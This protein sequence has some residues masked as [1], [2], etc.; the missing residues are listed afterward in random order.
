V[1]RFLQALVVVGMSLSIVLAGTAW[2]QSG[3]FAAGASAARSGTSITVSSITPCFSPVSGTPLVRVF[4]GRGSSTLARST[5]LV[6]SSG[7]WAGRLTIPSAA[8]PGSAQLSAFCFSGP[9]AEGAL[10][11]YTPHDFTIL[12]GGQVEELAATGRKSWRVLIGGV[13]LVFLGALIALMSSH[14]WIVTGPGERAD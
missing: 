8:S 1:R 4:L 6:S 7:R 2:A 10:L 12:S 14:A 11:A 5:F 9:Q 13:G 3:S